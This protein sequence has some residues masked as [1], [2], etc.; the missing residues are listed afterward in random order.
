MRGS[1]GG[2]NVSRETLDRLIHF[3]DLLLKWTKKINLIS[4]SSVS[5]IWDRHIWDSEQIVHLVSDQKSWVDLGSGAGFPGLVV[6]I[7]AKEIT[8][9]RCV[10]LV[11]SDQ[12]KAAFLRTV[13][14]ELD[15]RASVFVER[16]EAL[17]PAKADILSARALAD[18]DR[19]LGYAE[20]HLAP[21]GTALFM[22]GENWQKEV[23]IARNSWSFQLEAHKSKTSPEAAILEIKEIKRV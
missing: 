22:K 21:D 1:F 20:R 18:L 10:S 5:S 15:L 3:D 13:I 8:P 4:K 9:S 16:I 7:I 11:E 14:H 12:R 2:R 6:A 19:L 17:T 23:D